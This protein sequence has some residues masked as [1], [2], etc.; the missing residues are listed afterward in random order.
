M[1][2]S[3]RKDSTRTRNDHDVMWLSS[4]DVTVII[5]ATF[6]MFYERDF[7]CDKLLHSAY[8]NQIYFKSYLFFV[9][10]VL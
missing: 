8:L 4:Y 3:H 9:S 6:K 1:K 5:F 2:I 7:H 10:K